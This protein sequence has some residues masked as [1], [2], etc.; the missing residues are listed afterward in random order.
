MREAGNR[1]LHRFAVF[2]ACCT[3]LLVIAGALV[4]SN[5][6]GLAVPDWPLSYGTLFPPMVGGIFYEHGHR[7]IAGLVGILTILLAIWTQQRESRRWLRNLAWGALGLVVAQA[8]LG[9][10][11]V[12]FL[13]PPPVSSAHATLAELFFVTVFSIAVFTG[14]WWQS[15]LPQIED[16]GSPKLRSLTLWTSILIL[17][18]IVL[19]A[20]FRHN[21]FGIVPHLIGAVVVTGMVFW[22]VLAVS[23]RFKSVKD[24]RKAARY[25]EIALGLQLVLGGFAYWAVVAARD[26]VQPTPIYVT[27]TVLHVAVGA[28]TFAASVFLMLSCFRILTPSR[29]HRLETPVERALS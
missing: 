26:S 16:T 19:G 18:Q 20:A 10:I 7:M 1:N 3:F 28:L 11:T 21:A 2:T 8:V 23:R 14:K 24:L 17:V 5:E 22:T 15:G 29:S 13:L 12:K 4:T 9:G 6:A 25:L 27:L